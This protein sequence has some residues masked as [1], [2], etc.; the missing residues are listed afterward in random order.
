MVPTFRSI[1]PAPRRPWPWP[2]RSRSRLRASR[3]R[4]RPRPSRPLTRPR[5]RPPARPA[6]RAA[7]RPAAPGA[8]RGAEGGLREARA[9][10]RPAADPARRSQ[11]ADRPREPVVPRRLEEREAGA[12]RLRA[13][14]RAHDVPGL[15]ARARRVPVASSRRWARTCS[16]AA[17]TAR[18]TATAPTTSRPCRRP[19]SRRCCGSRATGWRR[20]STQTDQKKLDNQRD[21]V[22]NERRQGFEDPPYGRAYE[23]LVTQLRPRP[24]TPTRGRSSAAW[25]T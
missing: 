10:E 13:P 12:Q 3:R 14:L 15:D 25:R 8:D 19:T 7:S 17:S 9:A 16:R 6:P 2:R 18:P 4:A 23:L 1:R 21:V 24:A 11:A 5:R 20:C 22:K